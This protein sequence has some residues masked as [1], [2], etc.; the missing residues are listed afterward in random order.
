MSCDASGFP[1]PS[2]TWIKNG[3]VVSKLNQL[4]IQRSSRSDTGMYVCTA[5]NGVGQDKTAKVYVTVQCKSSRYHT[6]ELY[7]LLQTRLHFTEVARQSKFRNPL[8]HAYFNPRQEIFLPIYE[9]CTLI[10]LLLKLKFSRHDDK[11]AFEHI[12]II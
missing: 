4:G 5:S 10:H 8:T 9:L 7:Y 3:Q 2:L 11:G 1:E 12:N 6:T